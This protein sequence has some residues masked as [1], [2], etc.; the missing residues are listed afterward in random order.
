MYDEDKAAAYWNDRA[1]IDPFRAV[2]GLATSPTVNTAFDR[3]E[4]TLLRQWLRN[5]GGLTVL[6]IAG[7]VG[8][9]SAQL[10]AQGARVVMTDL[11]ER[12]LAYAQTEFAS[13]E[14]DVL[15]L[16]QA[17][18]QRLPLSDGSVDVALALGIVEH[19]TPD[20]RRAMFAEVRRL[21]APKGRFV[22]ATNNARSRYLQ[23]T[24]PYRTGEQLKNG[25]L[26]SL[27]PI[28]QVWTELDALDLE[29]VDARSNVAYSVLRR[30]AFREQG[31]GWYRWL[32]DRAWRSDAR[33]YWPP[34]LVDR[35]AD[36]VVS[37]WQ[38]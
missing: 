11:S 25:Y 26:Q 38:V 18:H 29:L 9:H 35:F 16:N 17:A 37:V 24:N 32:M 19:V 4:H 34:E 10:A 14:L 20:D 22:V 5:V 27:T 1:Q 8:R 6:D 13:R 15:L 7:G 21:L 12:M 30:R 3:W 23:R 36:H 33:W 31:S 28:G 2:V